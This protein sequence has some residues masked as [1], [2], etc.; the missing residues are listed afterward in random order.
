[1]INLKRKD[2]FSWSVSGGAGGGGHG[3]RERGPSIRL[4]SAASPPPPLGP[5]PFN[6]CPPDFF[7]SH[8]DL[9]LNSL[10]TKQSIDMNVLL[11]D[12]KTGTRFCLVCFLCCLF[13]LYSASTSTFFTHCGLYRKTTI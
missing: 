4:Y 2:L 6:F 3:E 5:W 1:M 13:T 10:L 12:E 9:F 11:K 8:Q 7:S